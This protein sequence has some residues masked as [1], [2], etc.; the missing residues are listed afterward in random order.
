V[1][2]A[3]LPYGSRSWTVSDDLRH[4][5][6]VSPARRPTEVVLEVS[7]TLTFASA[8]DWPGWCRSGKTPDDALR[9]LADYAERYAAVARIAHVRFAPAAADD[10]TVVDE[11]EGNATTGFGAPGKTAPT[12]DRD[13]TSSEA[14]RQ[15][16]L[17][18]ASWS[19]LDRLAVEAPEQLRKGPRGGGRDRDRV[20]DHVV[21]AE[22]SYARK[23]GVRHPPYHGDRAAIEACR[24]DI[25]RALRAAH[26]GEAGPAWTPRY[27]L[28]RATWH[29]LDHVWEI[30]DKSEGNP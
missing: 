17:L 24:A 30:E 29:V 15:V 18:E 5:A 8:V 28:R 27:F 16:R 13:L 2:P 3:S 7:R 26:P 11:T 6:L 25:A 10:L 22:R 9:V 19:E 4:A 12:D 21:E 23:I 20:V 14:D 1:H